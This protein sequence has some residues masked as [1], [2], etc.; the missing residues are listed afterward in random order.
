MLQLYKFISIN[1]ETDE[2]QVNVMDIIDSDVP[3][4]EEGDY[5]ELRFF[6][7]DNGETWYPFEIVLEPQDFTYNSS[8]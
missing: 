2:A 8:L 1:D 4:D 6:S 5:M 3:I 7:N